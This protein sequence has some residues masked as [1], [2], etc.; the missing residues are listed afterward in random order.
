MKFYVILVLEVLR[1]VLLKKYSMAEKTNKRK[2]M[3]GKFSAK[4]RSVLD[5]SLLA[6]E[7]FLKQLPFLIFIAV[8][9]LI[10]IANRYHAE[11]VFVLTE[12]NRK[13]I[14][15]LRSEKISIQSELMSRSRQNQVLGRLKEYNSDITV[16]NIPPRKISYSEDK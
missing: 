8:L 4:A 14:R 5:G 13:E 9:A 2:L 12:D 10:L 7:S 11:K 15:E 1:C 3:N 16:S 6:E